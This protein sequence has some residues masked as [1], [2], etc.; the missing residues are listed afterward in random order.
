MKKLILIIIAL[1]N[2]GL[3]NASN[4]LLTLYQRVHEPYTVTVVSGASILITGKQ[5]LSV[6]LEAESSTQLPNID[7]ELK[8]EH[9]KE[10]LMIKFKPSPSPLVY[11]ADIQINHAGVW[12]ANLHLKSVDSSIDF[13]FSLRLFN[14]QFFAS[15]VISLTIIILGLISFTVYKPQLFSTNSASKV[16]YGF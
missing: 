2:Y 4:G 11:T 9:P 6:I 5:H 13:K 1:F 12:Q 15:L 14:P 10:S 3:V 7:L 8:L 16:T